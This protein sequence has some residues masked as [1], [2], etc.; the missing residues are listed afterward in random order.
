MQNLVAALNGEHNS[1]FVMCLAN[2]ELQHVR[3]MGCWFVPSH[4]RC[5]VRPGR[6]SKSLGDVTCVTAFPFD[7]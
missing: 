2:K 3:P 4:T 6:G 7:T 5:V 1:A